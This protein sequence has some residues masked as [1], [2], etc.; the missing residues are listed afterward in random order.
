MSRKMP[1]RSRSTRWLNQDEVEG[2]EK[3]GPCPSGKVQGEQ[4]NPIWAVGS[5]VSNLKT[6]MRRLRGAS[7][8][9]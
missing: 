1:P 5:Q 6:Q 9:L 3:E 7:K 2:A 4:A 8:N